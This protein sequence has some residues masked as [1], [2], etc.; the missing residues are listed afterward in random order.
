MKRVND[1]VQQDLSDLIRIHVALWQCRIQLSSDRN[2]MPGESLLHHFESVFNDL[3]DVRGPPLNR[4]P[5]CERQELV[6]DLR[7]AFDLIDDRL[8]SLGRLW[9]LRLPLEKLG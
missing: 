5:P 9:I 8:Q 4:S 1:E 6:H 7:D 2:M 3:V